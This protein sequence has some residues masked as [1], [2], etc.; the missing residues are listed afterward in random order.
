MTSCLLAIIAGA[1]Y[2]FPVDVVEGSERVPSETVKVG[3]IQFEPK[4][5]TIY[6]DGFMNLSGGFVEYLVNLPSANAHECLVAVD[7]DPANFQTA[8]MLLDLKESRSPES[9]RD[10]GPLDDGDRVVIFLQFA[11]ED[12]EGR[13]LIRTIRAENC[14]INA[15]M[16]KEM[17]RCGFAFTGSGFMKIDPPPS[18]PEGTPPKEEFMARVTG[19]L[20][21]LSH[22]PWA[23]LDNPLALP[24]TDGD[25]FAYS[26]VLPKMRRNDQR[27]EPPGVR[28]ILRKAR[29]FEIDASAVRMELPK[30]EATPA[31]EAEEDR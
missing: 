30:L 23:I 27:D 16:E 13:T 29:S 3:S 28:V 18:A 19:E 17:A 26:D 9:N 7:C 6:L 2:G 25:Y 11:I 15:P 24:Y 20:I 4:T 8:L 22:R 1:L 14:I 21:S 10:L 12:A 31:D 5:K